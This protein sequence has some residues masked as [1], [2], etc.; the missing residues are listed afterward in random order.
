MSSEAPHRPRSGGTLFIVSAP[1]GTGKTTVV[2]RLVE[3]LE[4][5]TISRSYTSRPARVGERDGL[6]YNFVSRERFEAM[7]AGGEFLEWADVFGHVYGTRREDT[8]QLMASGQDVILVIDVQGAKQLRRQT[9][10]AVSVFVLPPCYEV[11]EQRLRGRSQDTEEAIHRRL[12]TA[13]REVVEYH[14]YDYVIVNDDL[15][16]C[17][18]ALSAVIVAERARSTNV[19]PIAEAIIRTFPGLTG[20]RTGTA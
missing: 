18:H 11:L 5:V 9:L 1:S 13:R 2:E 10:D 6:D 4:G 8:E 3:V 12:D 14:D 16:T 7:V 20:R 15:D 19:E 17:V